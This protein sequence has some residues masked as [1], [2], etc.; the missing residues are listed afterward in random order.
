MLLTLHNAEEAIAFWR[1]LPRTKALLP[2]PF[3]ALESNLSYAALVQALGILSV[4]AFALAIIANA[5]PRSERLLWLMLALQAA[6]GLNVLA[7]L[8]SAAFVF[9]GYGPGLITAILVNAPFTAYCFLRAKREVWVSPKA[10]RATAPVAL[11]L[12]GP[13]LLA[14][15]WLAGILSR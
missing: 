3:A 8:T 15:L 6:I 4:L 9:R 2:P 13:V 11:I 14:G 10:L 7:H 12:H 5:R 1:Y